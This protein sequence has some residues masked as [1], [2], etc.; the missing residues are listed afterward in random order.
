MP[1][2][3]ILLKEIKLH[4]LILFFDSLKIGSMLK[5]HLAILFNVPERTTVSEVCNLIKDQW[6]IYQLSDIPKEWHI[7]ETSSAKKERLY[8]ESY[9]KNVEKSWLDIIPKKSREL[10][11]NR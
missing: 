5:N 8:K 1:S 2:I 9:Q 3:Y 10:P 6:Q 4:F 11:S 7:I